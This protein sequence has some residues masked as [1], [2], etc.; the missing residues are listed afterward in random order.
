[1][2]GREG[3]F[4]IGKT[5]THYRILEE[6]GR[7]GMGVVY[8]AE[9]IKLDRSVA[10][11]V[12]SPHLSSDEKAVARFVHEAKAASAL[13]HANI[14]AIYEIDETQAG[15]TFIAMA[16]YEGETLRERLDRG[17]MEIDEALSI[18]GQV[19]GGLE[20]AHGAGIVHRDIKPS[21]IIMTRHGEAKVIDFGLAKLAGGTKLTREGSTF[22]TAAYMSPEQ[23]LGEEMDHR[24]DIFSLGVIFYEMLAGERPFRGEHEVALLYEIVHEKPQSLQDLGIDIDPAIE[25]IIDRVLAKDRDK[26]YE[27]VSEFVTDLVALREG[28]LSD[29][30]TTPSKFRRRPARRSLLGIGVTALAVAIIITALYMTLWRGETIDSIAVLPLE[31]L[32][33]DDDEEYFVNGLTDELI[34]RL[35]RIGGL[36]VISRTSVMQY[37]GS[38][39]PL[40]KIAGELNVKAVLEGSVLRIGNRVRIAV[41]LIHAGTDRS[42]WAESYERDIHDILRLQSEVALDVARNIKIKLTSL[43][44]EEITGN[45]AVSAEAHEAYLKGRYYVDQRTPDALNKGLKYFELSIEK[46]SSY[47]L[48][49]AGIADTYLL[50]AAYSLENPDLIYPKARQA[51][52]K[53]IKLDGRLAE[54]HTSLAIVKWHYEWEFDEAEREFRRAV[55]L[56]PNYTRA[57]HWYALYLSFLERYDE[58]I[59]EMRKAQSVDPVSLIANAALGLVYYYADR[60]DEALEQSIQ[61][62]EMDDQFFP[63]YTVQGRAYTRKS[64]YSEAIEAFEKVIEISGRRSSVLSLI[65]HPL[66]ASGDVNKAE[67]LYDEL[68]ERSVDE[69]IS[70][71]DMAVLT[72]ALGRKPETLN[73]LE[74]A[75]DEKT[76]DIMSMNAEP[77]LKD[78]RDEPRFFE[79]TDKI[80]LTFD[81]N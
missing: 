11:K 29:S 48:A 42:I 1:M 50:L 7:G 5:I 44:R 33:K 36:K 32:S 73:W 69:Y 10:I 52:L 15:E 61:T 74:R 68:R 38:S 19:A 17:G 6:L 70:P 80:G 45:V 35:A 60:Y 9:D 58:A 62:L 3:I 78:L 49:Y 64:M 65:A 40:P 16:Y 21:N 55:V 18:I 34:S 63:A 13:D 14:G 37:R 24:S 25:S 23:A 4:M 28:R 27:R 67:E 81:R 26:R 31:N 46:D 76:F 43:D 71:F 8:K 72:M 77:L 47:A 59:A 66:A 2:Y 54:A 41:K 39:K 75:Y 12:L 51:A 79:L 22:G 57:H 53:A 30:I 56:N 20:R